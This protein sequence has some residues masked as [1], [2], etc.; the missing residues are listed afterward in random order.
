[1]ERFAESDPVGVERHACMRIGPV[2]LQAADRKNIQCAVGRRENID[3]GL[4][5][6]KVATNQIGGDERPVDRFAETQPAR[7]DG[8]R[9]IRSAPDPNDL[10]HSLPFARSER[11]DKILQRTVEQTSHPHAALVVPAR[12]ERA[13]VGPEKQRFAVVLPLRL[14]G[15]RG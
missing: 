8:H 1:M 5:A 14:P 13:F 11:K 10:Q 7:D 2:A 12:P 6:G 4:A 15:D 9:R 3:R